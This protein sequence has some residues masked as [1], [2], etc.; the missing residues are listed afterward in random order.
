MSWACPTD[1]SG[2]RDQ[3]RSPLLSFRRRA[4]EYHPREDVEKRFQPGRVLIPVIFTLVA[5][6]VFAASWALIGPA[7]PA[8]F[9]SPL[10]GNFAAISNGN[11][12][13]KEKSVTEILTS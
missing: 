1:I 4:T 6:G 13:V 9:R 3:T 12:D 7:F 10:P 8:T 5:K 2:I 11:F